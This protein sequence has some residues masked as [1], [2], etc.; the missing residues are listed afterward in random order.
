[1]I[2]NRKSEVLRKIQYNFMHEGEEDII[3]ERYH[4]DKMDE[5]I[6]EKERNANTDRSKTEVDDLTK[7]SSIYENLDGSQK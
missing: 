2:E 6:K 4:Q 5:F 7:R 1:M 3:T